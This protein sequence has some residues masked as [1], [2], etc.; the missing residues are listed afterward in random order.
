MGPG[1]ESGA[2][3]PGRVIEECAK[4]NPA[5]YPFRADTR[6]PLMYYKDAVRSIVELGAAPLDRIKT[7]IY[8]VDGVSPTPSSQE[9][10]EAIRTKIPDASVQLQSDPQVQ[11]VVDEVARPI[12]DNNARRE[13][14]WKPHF[15]LERMVEDFLQELGVSPPNCH[16]REGVR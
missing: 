10:A 15:D 9:L 2:V 16:R 3:N 13:W 1:K 6:F 5:V 14:G 4:G 12:D 7:V 11:R 8:V